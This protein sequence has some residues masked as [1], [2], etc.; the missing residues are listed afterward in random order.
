MS[1]LIASIFAMET[2]ERIC[3]L[4]AGER[5]LLNRRSVLDRPVDAAV[6]GVP[7]VVAVAPAA[8]PGAA[9][10]T[11]A[12]PALPLLL[13]AMLAAS[14]SATILMTAA[15]VAHLLDVR[16]LSPNALL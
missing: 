8:P 14:G 12:P 7:R 2:L 10:A 3:A 9:P 5:F 11:P 1:C 16:G 13:E 4:A 6:D 15:L